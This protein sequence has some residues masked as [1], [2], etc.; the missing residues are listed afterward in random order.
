[1]E[2]SVD[3]ELQLETNQKVEKLIEF[4]NNGIDLIKN[5]DYEKAIR[6]FENESFA[7]S[8][9]LQLGDSKTIFLHNDLSNPQQIDDVL[10]FI[11]LHSHFNHKYSEIKIAGLINSKL[12][13][14]K[15][16]YFVPQDVWKDVALVNLEEWLHAVQFISKQPIAGE[17]DDE[18]DVALY[19]RAKGIPLTEHF[20][21]MHGRN[22][23]IN[24]QKM[25]DNLKKH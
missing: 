8:V 3:H 20:L 17:D 24:G 25:N 16:K 21:S 23:F 11:S 7:E 10:N 6:Y 15:T 19:M 2:S 13:P 9:G 5:G 12:H 4:T 22:K 18:I 1:M 14:E